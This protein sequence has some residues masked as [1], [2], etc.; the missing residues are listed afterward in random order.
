MYFKST[1]NRVWTISFS[2][3]IRN[4]SHTSMQRLLGP[5]TF[6]TALVWLNNEIFVPDG[7]S[8][9]NKLM[10]DCG[11]PSSKRFLE[12]SFPSE[13][14]ISSDFI[15]SREISTSNMRR[16][17]SYENWF[18]KIRLTRFTNQ[19][20]CHQNQP[21]INKI[22]CCAKPSENN[23]ARFGSKKLF[24][25]VTEAKSLSLCVAFIFINKELNFYLENE[26]TNNGQVFHS[27][28]RS[29]TVPGYDFTASSNE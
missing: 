25:H 8:A 18:E 4:I 12:L 5:F 24:V 3:D 15:T 23:N 10:T 7:Y 2:V 27:I 20:L 13:L 29:L 17:F 22:Q 9:W 19:L 14:T 28:Y 16:C 21:G 1:S 6:A 26:S 11:C